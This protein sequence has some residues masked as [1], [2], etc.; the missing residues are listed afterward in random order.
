MLKLPVLKLP[1]FKIPNITLDLS[2]IDLGM[3]I[4]LPKFQFVPT[5]VPLPQIPDLPQP[6]TIAIPGIN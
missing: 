6:P 4:L 5:S 3:E 2:H 1:P